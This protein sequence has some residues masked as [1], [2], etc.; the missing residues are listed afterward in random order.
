M[1]KDAIERTF[2]ERSDTDRRTK[3]NRRSGVEVPPKRELADTMARRSKPDRR[4]G[5]DQRTD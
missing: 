1:Q 5:K 2:I 4:S 3:S